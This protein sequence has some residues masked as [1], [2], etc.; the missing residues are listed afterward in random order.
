MSVGLSS[1]NRNA[2]RNNKSITSAL[3]RIIAVNRPI[4]E[5]NA[6]LDKLKSKYDRQIKSEVDRLLKNEELPQVKEQASKMFPKDLAILCEKG[7]HLYLAEKAQR[8]NEAQKSMKLNLD[9]INQS[10]FRQQRIDYRDNSKSLCD[11]SPSP[12]DDF[13]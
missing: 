8:E 5:F 2:G 12:K 11:K 6:K 3:T 9:D 4:S 13:E 10:Y 7:R 1:H